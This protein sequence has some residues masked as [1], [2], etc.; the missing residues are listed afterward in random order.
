LHKYKNIK[1]NTLIGKV[2]KTLSVSSTSKSAPAFSTI[3]SRD[4][5]S[6]SFKSEHISSVSALDIPNPSATSLN[7]RQITV[8]DFLETANPSR[9]VQQI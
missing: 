2:N 6:S 8:I 9:S 4:T 3:A 1:N 5:F 7:T